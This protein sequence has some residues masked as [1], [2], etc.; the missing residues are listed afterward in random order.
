MLLLF[1]LGN[2]SG[3][4]L[5]SSY[6]YDVILCTHRISLVFRYV[7]SNACSKDLCYKQKGTDRIFHLRIGEHSHLHWMDTAR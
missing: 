5:L 1:S 3:I 7:I 2:L 4:L 6:F